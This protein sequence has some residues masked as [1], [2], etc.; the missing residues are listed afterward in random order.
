M[1]LI[2][3]FVT[4]ALIGEM[5]MRRYAGRRALLAGGL[6]SLLPDIDVAA[7]LFFDPAMAAYLHR[8]ITHSFF[9]A[10]VCS[11]VLAA[12]AGK[13]FHTHRAPFFHAAHFY[14]LV[15]L[16]HILLD[17][18]TAYGIGLFEPFSQER[19]TTNTIFVADP[20]YTLPLLIVFVLLVS[21]RHQLLWRKV[22]AYAGIAWATLY[23]AFTMVNKI[24]VHGV[25]KHNLQQ[26][27]ISYREFMTTPA[28]LNNFLWYAVVQVDRGCYTTYYSILDS[29]RRVTFDYVPKNELILTLFQDNEIIPVLKKFSKGYYCFT[30]KG[31]QVY[32][33]DLRFGRAA[34]WAVKDSRWVFSYS[35]TNHPRGVKVLDRRPMEIPLSQ[36]LQTLVTRARGKPVIRQEIQP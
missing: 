5:T 33:N 18:F 25:I 30:K 23:M 1:D 13:L 15:L 14:F 16:S 31:W 17:L 6:V 9:F 27:G 20:F 34:G 21:L 26:Q 19:Y 22:A 12:L 32:F 28:P 2:S 3:H 7:N 8:G 4:G 11:P 10:I 29:S 36:A 24:H 35:I